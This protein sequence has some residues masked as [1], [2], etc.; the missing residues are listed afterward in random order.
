MAPLRSPCQEESTQ[1]ATRS[2]ALWDPIRKLCDDTYNLVLLLRGLED[3]Y[4]FEFPKSGAKIDDTAEPVA[5]E[6]AHHATGASRNQTTSKEVI[7]FT[8][9]G[10][11]VKY[12]KN[13][14]AKRLVLEKAHVVVK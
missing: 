9:F 11:L 13:N 7:S 10:S 4:T 6:Y 1:T 2:R 8:T 12:P 14:M 3:T 5:R